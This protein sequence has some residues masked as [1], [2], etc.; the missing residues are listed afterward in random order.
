MFEEILQSC[1]TWGV[2]LTVATF[3][4]GTYL[5][6]ITGKAWC[7]P[8][9]LSCIFVI[10]FLGICGIPYAEY[11]ESSETVSYLLLPATVSL[12]IPMYEKWTL[13]KQNILAIAA[14]ILSGVLTSLSSIWII[15]VVLKLTREQYVTLLPK[16]V[17]TAIGMDIVEE[18]GGIASLASAVIILTGITGALLA[19][20]ICKLFHIKN[21]VSRGIAI[22]TSA[23]AIGTAKAIEMGETEGAMSSLAIV[24]AG[25]LTALLAPIFAG[26]L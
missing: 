8:L 23:H 12:A 9:L 17:T 14:G 16:S 2:L 25:I 15:A 13:L 10:T 21:P 22:G 24:I 1:T 6:R 19:E 5:N 4:F 3:A 26:L 11:K 20:K 18:L 7:N